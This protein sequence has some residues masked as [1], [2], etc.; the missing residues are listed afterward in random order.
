MDLTSPFIGNYEFFFLVFEKSIQLVGE[1]RPGRCIEP[2]NVAWCFASAT[3]PRRTR[4]SR[5]HQW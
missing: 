2:P 1:I 3:Q 4:A 5:Q